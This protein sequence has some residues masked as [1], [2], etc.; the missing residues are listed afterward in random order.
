[1]LSRT[2][3]RTAI[4]MFALASSATTQAIAKADCDKVE[5]SAT[6]SFSGPNTV[7]TNVDLVVGGSAFDAVSVATL[8]SSTVAGDGATFVQTTHVFTVGTSTFTTSDRA[9][10]TPTNSPTVVRLHS[11]SEITGGTGQYVGASGSTIAHG[12]IDF[13]DGSVIWEL[14]GKI[15]AA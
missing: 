11:R 4:A 13:A 5:G 12:F 3:I 15:C 9:I 1:M 14:K 6:G 2:R 7:T 10:L 8:L